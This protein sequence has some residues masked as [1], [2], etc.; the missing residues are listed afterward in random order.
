M[1][2]RGENKTLLKIR[3]ATMIGDLI[4]KFDNLEE[5]TVK[6]FNEL[7][8]NSQLV[9]YNLTDEVSIGEMMGANTRLVSVNGNVVSHLIS[10]SVKITQKRA[11]SQKPIAVLQDGK[12]LFRTN[13]I[14]SAAKTLNVVTSTIR[15]AFQDD[16]TF[17][18]V[19]RGVSGVFKAIPVTKRSK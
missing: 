1:L 18:G 13:S 15:R 8:V 16:R 6:T 2:I 11:R 3:S 12:L 14:L 7:F 10:P 4:N 9:G 19:Y 17:K 5:Q